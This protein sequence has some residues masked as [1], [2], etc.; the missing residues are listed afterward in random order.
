MPKLTPIPAREVVRK[1]RALGYE[2]PFGG[3]K[4]SVMR[5]PETSV[6]ISVPVHSSRDLPIGTLRAI[7]RE[8]GVSVE[9]WEQL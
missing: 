9:E 7:V 8:A 4:H 1:L 5:H 6:K 3:G 2:G